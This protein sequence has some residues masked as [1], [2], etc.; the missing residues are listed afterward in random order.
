MNAA[1]AGGGGGGYE[2]VRLKGKGGV[3]K[4]VD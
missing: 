1:T 3:K 2:Y 4:G